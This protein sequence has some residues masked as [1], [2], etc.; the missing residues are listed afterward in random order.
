LVSGAESLAATK[1]RTASTVAPSWDTVVVG[2]GVFGA[3]TAWHLRAAGERVLLVD[4]HA[5]AHARASSGGESRAT[6]SKG[7]TTMSC[8]SHFH[9]SSPQRPPL[10]RCGMQP[11]A[12][13]MGNAFYFK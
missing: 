9:R 4:A 2:A 11:R 3:W 10:D 5:P 1:R 7:L 8:F 6:H 13:E 12:E